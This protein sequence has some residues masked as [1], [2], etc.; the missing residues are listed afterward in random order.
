MTT[1]E[2][3]ADEYRRGSSITELSQRFSVP[4]STIRFRLAKLGVL[5]SRGDGVRGAARKG[6]MGRPGPRSPV[7]DQTRENMRK[8]ARERCDAKGIVGTSVKPSGYVEHTVGPHKGRSVHVVKMEE[9]I[10]RRLRRDEVVHHIDHN[11][12][13]NDINNLALMTRAAHA[14]LHRREERIQRKAA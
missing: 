4:L 2:Q 13:N 12:A 11:R 10:G 1:P 8:A 14:R 7:S 6:K 3:L 9:R 5:R